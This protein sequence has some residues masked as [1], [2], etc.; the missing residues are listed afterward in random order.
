MVNDYLMYYGG[1]RKEFQ[2]DTSKDKRDM[3]VVKIHS[4]FMWSEEDVPRSWEERLA[5][6]YWDRLFKEYS[7]AD[8]SRYKEN[9]LGLRWRSKREVASGKGQFVCGSLSCPEATSLRSWE[10]NFAYVEQGTKRNA[11][12]KLRLCPRCSDKLNYHKQHVEYILPGRKEECQDPERDPCDAEQE[13]TPA[14]KKPTNEDGDTAA[15]SSAWRSSETSVASDT[16]APCE[17]AFE[18][19]FKDM[20]M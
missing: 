6:R 9:K 3:D 16:A 8:L 20:F 11:L 13:E 5:K 12:V 7:I 17:D 19:Y 10:V 1:S 15:D 18:D 4:R 14:T 2:R